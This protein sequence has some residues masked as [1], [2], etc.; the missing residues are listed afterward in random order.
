MSV[1]NVVDSVGDA[2]SALLEFIHAVLEGGNLQAWRVEIWG[3]RCEGECDYT[4]IYFGLCSSLEE[5]KDLF[6][7][8]AAHAIMET[9]GKVPYEE[10]HGTEWQGIYDR[11]KE[12]YL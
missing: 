2:P 3:C 8:E 11:L 10:W 1:L 5:T 12:R 4:T 9:K 6:L 7:H